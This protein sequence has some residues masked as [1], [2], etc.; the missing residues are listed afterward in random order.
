MK[1]MNNHA[2]KLAF[3]LTCTILDA[4][5]K[6]TNQTPT[7]TEIYLIAQQ[8]ANTSAEIFPDSEIFVTL[9]ENE[10]SE[11]LTTGSAQQ[12]VNH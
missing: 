8:S 1:I 4:K 6:W 10:I 5:M 2:Q 12:K 3:D 11:F 9:I 7:P